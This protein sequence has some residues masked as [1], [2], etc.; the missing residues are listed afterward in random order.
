MGDLQVSDENSMPDTD[1]FGAEIV[2]G[3]PT[4]A[5]R[6]TYVEAT[7]ERIVDLRA[8]QFSELAAMLV[9]QDKDAADLLM[10]K[11]AEAIDAERL[12]GAT[13]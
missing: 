7:V 4:S 6:A 5:R 11:L 10:R 1:M 3:E 13:E 2:S 12:V 8:R 9:A